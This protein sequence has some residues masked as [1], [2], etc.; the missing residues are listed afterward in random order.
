MSIAPLVFPCL[1]I[2]LLKLGL[3]YHLQCQ[4]SARSSADIRCLL[5]SQ[6]AGT[7]ELSQAWCSRRQGPSTLSGTRMS[8]GELSQNALRS[9]EAGG[10]SF[11]SSCR[12]LQNH[13]SRQGCK[14]LVLRGKSC[15]WICQ[16]GAGSHS[17]PPTGTSAFQSW[18][19]GERALRSQPTIPGRCRK[20]QGATHTLRHTALGLTQV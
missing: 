8:C 6:T 2:F 4:R 14:H 19:T 5:L 13:C 12:S 17:A 16:L 18:K 10:F 11:L 7:T 20:F 3:L 1:F 9:L 15:C